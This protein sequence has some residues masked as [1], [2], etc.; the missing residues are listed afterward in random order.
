MFEYPASSGDQC[1]QR[2]V[3][4]FHPLRNACPREFVIV[5]HGLKYEARVSK[6]GVSVE[7]IARLKKAAESQT[8]KNLSNTQYD[9]PLSDISGAT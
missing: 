6:T 4:G 3:V 8:S 2:L 5:R 7:G 1:R 9:E